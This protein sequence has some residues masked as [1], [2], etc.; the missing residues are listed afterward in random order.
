[1]HDGP[2]RC[3][4]CAA[5]QRRRYQP[6]RQ[7]RRVASG[8]NTA[9]WA[10]LRKIVIERDGGCVT[11]GSVDDL[12]ADHI[13]PARHGGKTVLENLQ[14]LCRSCNARKGAR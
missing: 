7:Q 9:L 8:R 12:T 4:S 3:P 10:K 2:A 13:V 11:C 6:A 14:C 1:M 5:E